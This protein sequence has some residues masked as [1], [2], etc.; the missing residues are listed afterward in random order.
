ML[1]D[2]RSFCALTAGA[3]CAPGLARA[4]NPAPPLTL[5]E[6]FT[7]QGCSSCP[8]ADALMLELSK[9]SGFLPL[10]F[11][12][13]IWDYLGWRDTLAKPAF[14]RRQKAY[15]A[16]VAS[17]R[18]YTPQAIV[19]GKASCIGSDLSAIRKLRRAST[20]GAQIAVDHRIES[21]HHALSV[22]LSGLSAPARLMVLPVADRVSVPIGRG[23][24][25]GRT[26]TYA[27]VVR[28]L[29]DHGPVENGTRRFILP[30][31]QIRD[32]GANA[33]ALIVQGGAL[34]SPGEVFASAF[35]GPAAA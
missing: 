17:K 20:N 6:L 28:D 19:N 8:P 32:V 15:A 11:A 22:T 30:Q 31:A 1:L 29:L 26:V 33:L 27:N 12:V 10:T 7:S 35:I 18:V 4:Q 2:R 25:S 5:I 16:T 23:E 9:E 14:T 21:G 13:E 3:L 24:N 34:E